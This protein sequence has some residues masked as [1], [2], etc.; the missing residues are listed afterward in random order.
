MFWHCK[1]TSAYD[2]HDAVN[3]YAGTAGPSSVWY[4]AQANSSWEEAVFSIRRWN[5]PSLVLNRAWPVE[6]AVHLSNKIIHLHHARVRCSNR[7]RSFHRICSYCIE[8]TL[9]QTFCVLWICSYCMVRL[10]IVLIMLFFSASWNSAM[11]FVKKCMI[12]YRHTSRIVDKL[13]IMNHQPQLKEF[14]SMVYH[15]ARY[16]NL[17]YF[18]STLQR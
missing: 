12:G 11:A 7:D 10:L 3:S 1:C 9:A 2:V 14:S 13:F 17:C 8:R 15:M 5:G 16:L 6:H 18:S 4:E